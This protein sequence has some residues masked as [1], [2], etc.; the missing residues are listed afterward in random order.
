MLTITVTPRTTDDMRAFYGFT[1]EQNAALDRLLAAANQE[2]WNTLLY[3]SGGEI[4]AGALSQVGN[5]G[6]QP[7][8]IW[9]GFNS[10]VE[11]CANE[12]G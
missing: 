3:G 5:A 10:R 7:Y 11:W 6:G 1:E 2:M 12:C 9:Y 8:R 4:G